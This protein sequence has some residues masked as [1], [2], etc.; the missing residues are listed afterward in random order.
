MDW[1][2]DKGLRYRII[3]NTNPVYGLEQGKEGLRP[4]ISLHF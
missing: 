1:N 4:N 3:H 2:R